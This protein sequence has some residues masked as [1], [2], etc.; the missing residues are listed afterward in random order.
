V[1]NLDAEIA[2][3]K[4]LGVKFSMDVMPTPGCNFAIILDPD[5]NRVMIHK[6]KAK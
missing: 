3:L 6:R 4:S 2:R 5:G 1:D